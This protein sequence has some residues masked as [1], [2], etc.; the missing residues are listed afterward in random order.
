MIY[1]LLYER[2]HPKTF[3]G[4]KN[5][6]DDSINREEEGIFSHFRRWGDFV[7]SRKIAE[8]PLGFFSH[9]LDSP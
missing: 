2:Y 3:F 7:K 6:K 4:Q 8:D 1:L 5:F 9:S